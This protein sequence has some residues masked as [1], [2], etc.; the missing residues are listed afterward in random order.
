M[1]ADWNLFLTLLF[2]F[3]YIPIGCSQCPCIPLPN[4]CN[5]YNECLN[6][7]FSCGSDGYAL[8]SGLRYCNEFQ[9]YYS[10]F[11][12]QGQQW[13]TAV[14]LCLQNALIPIVNEKDDTSCDD[15]ETFAMST[16]T[17]C[18]TNP[19]QSICDI[20]VTDWITL[21]FII[22]DELDDS[23]TQHI[24]LNVAETCGSVYYKDI[25]GIFNSLL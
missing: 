13:V 20:P 7:K 24:M 8:K 18:Y 22:R 10:L 4:Q 19:K 14:G 12:P 17:G 11:S 3:L 15:I 23:A 9:K 16:H 21:L 25:L 2:G 5:F 1:F 6:E